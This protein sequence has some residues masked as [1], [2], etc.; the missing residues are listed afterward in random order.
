MLV[1]AEKTAECRHN[2]ESSSFYSIF[3]LTEKGHCHYHYKEF[4][5][6]KIKK[7]ETKIGIAA[8]Y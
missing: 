1:E 7:G 2:G 5:G 8:E 4:Y 3:S 6:C